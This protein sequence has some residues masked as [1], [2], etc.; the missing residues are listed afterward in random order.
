MSCDE[1]T[2]SKSA[3]IAIAAAK[4]YTAL[5]PRLP[6]V[7][8]RRHRDQRSQT[9]FRSHPSPA[10]GQFGPGAP[11]GPRPVNPASGVLAPL[12]GGS[13]GGQMAPQQYT[14]QPQQLNALAGL[15]A[16]ASLPASLA[17]PSPPQL[18]QQSAANASAAPPQPVP[19]RLPMAQAD[20]QP[21]RSPRLS[22]AGRCPLRH[23]LPKGPVSRTADTPSG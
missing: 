13:R 10:V 20:E 2:C 22:K 14:A 19:G 17:A 4:L 6:L 23:R 7:G 8:V 21:P 11:E 3:D 15:G 5:V 1:S 12:T 18:I 16:A 9:G